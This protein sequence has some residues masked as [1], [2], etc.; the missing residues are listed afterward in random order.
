M[1]KIMHSHGC[2]FARQHC[3]SLGDQ[4]YEGLFQSLALV[5]PERKQGKYILPIL[6]KMT[7]ILESIYL[8]KY[9]TELVTQ[10]RMAIINHA[11]PFL[12][13]K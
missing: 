3:V 13:I 10:S 8:L 11:I 1:S 12:L 5:L 6:K 4:I 7:L 2:C 9:T